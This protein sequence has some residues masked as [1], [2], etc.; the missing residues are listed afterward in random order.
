MKNLA[1]CKPS[2]FVAQTAKIKDAVSDWAKLI[3]LVEIRSVQ[4]NYKQAPADATAE[5]RAEV[6]RENA[7]IKQAQAIENMNRILDGM[8]VEHPQETLNVLALCCFVEPADVDNHTMDEYLQCILDMIQNKSV[9]SF[10]SLLAQLEQKPTL[11][12]LNP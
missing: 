1:N 6:I 8:L 9:L 4:P 11:T 12:V 5:Q 2:E 3:K 10:F 7:K